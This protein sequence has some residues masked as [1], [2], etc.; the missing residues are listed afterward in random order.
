MFVNGKLFS[1]IKDFS[2][3]FLSNIISTAVSVVTVL[4]VPKFINVEQYGYYQL[5]N[6]Y[7]NYVCMA[8]LGWCEGIYL[9]VGGQ[10]YKDLDR[11]LY[12]T[13]FWLLGAFVS[14]LYLII[15]KLALTLSADV[16]RR[17]VFVAVCVVAI[18]CCLRYY[19][20]YIMQATGLIKYDAV[21]RVS[22]KAI[23]A[24]LAFV[25]L[26]FGVDRFEKIVFVDAIAKF[27]SLFISVWYCR[28]IVFSKIEKP[29][30]IF[31]E[32]FENISAGIKLML[33]SLCGM[34][35]IGIVRF[36]I[37]S[38]WDISTFGKV[39][40]TLNISNMIMTAINAIAIVVYP[41]LRRTNEKRLPEIY[42]VLRTILLS[43]VYFVLLFYYPL[44]IVITLWLPQYAESVQ[45]VA[46]LFPICAYESKMSLLIN[47]YFKT[48][49]LEKSLM[50]CNMATLALSLILTLLSTTVFNS[51]RMAI[52]SILICLVFR[53]VLG[54][55]VLSSH[56]SIKIFA[57]LLT[58]LFMTISFVVCNWFFGLPGAAA[59]AVLYAMYLFIRRNKLRE[60]ILYLKN[61]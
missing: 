34:L 22:E 55:V 58:D 31:K 52:V 38:R 16:G 14:I 1:F 54:E 61:V 10:Y 41:M 46:I 53:G 4:I 45:Y 43:F 12:C 13:Q 36:G 18:V 7:T 19:L 29:K 50:K 49:R 32:V 27:M 47:T 5:Y 28:D 35:T 57:E 25:L 24:V 42:G 60:A 21:V 20:I 48:L 9:R 23:F 39:S 59:Y 6:F 33:S 15:L 40:L 37:Q 17:Y 8:C 44:K 51:V 56:I 11:S 3:S 30:Y 26:A 2:Y